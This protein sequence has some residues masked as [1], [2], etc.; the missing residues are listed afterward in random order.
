MVQSALTGKWPKGKRP[1][2]WD[3]KTA[4]RAAASLKK[5]MARRS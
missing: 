2:R 5:F 3:G 4:E 1:D